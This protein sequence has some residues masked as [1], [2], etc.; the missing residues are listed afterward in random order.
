MK[1]S[2]YTRQR[3]AFLR[4]QVPLVIGT[5]VAP[6][7]PNDFGTVN[8]VSSYAWRII[9]YAGAIHFRIIEQVEHIK[10]TV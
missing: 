9:M 10:L 1:L 5:A 8:T 3:V 7:C 4:T 2:V 6:S